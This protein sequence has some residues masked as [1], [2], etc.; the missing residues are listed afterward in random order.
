MTYTKDSCY[1]VQKTLQHHAMAYYV[2][3]VSG[4]LLEKSFLHM[5]TVVLEYLTDFL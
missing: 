1:S 4:M 2:S 5:A 3:F